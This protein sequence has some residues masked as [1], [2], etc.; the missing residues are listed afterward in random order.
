M[1]KE[2]KKPKKMKIKIKKRK[3]DK[4]FMKII[5]EKTKY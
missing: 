4:K 2:D 3:M 1:I 5:K